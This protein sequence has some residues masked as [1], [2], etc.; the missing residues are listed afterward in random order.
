VVNLRLAKPTAWPGR[1]DYRRGILH[2]SR[3]RFQVTT[4]P[5]GRRGALRDSCNGI[6]D[7]KDENH[8][9]PTSEFMALHPHGHEF[10]S[11]PQKHPVIPSDFSGSA[12]EEFFQKVYCG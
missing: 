1:L 6:F 9:Q 12:T 7:M 11:N 4:W 8:I 3:A 10:V 2:E 5:F